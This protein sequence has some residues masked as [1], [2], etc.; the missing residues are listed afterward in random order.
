MSIYLIADCLECNSQFS[1]TTAKEGEQ[2][3]CPNCTDRQPR[4][5]LT[6][7]KPIPNNIAGEEW[8]KE[9][10][11]KFNKLAVYDIQGPREAEVT[12]RDVTAIVKA[13][14]HKTRQEAIARERLRIE[15]KIKNFDVKYGV[16]GEPVT[17][18]L[19]HIEDIKRMILESLQ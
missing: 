16:L 11:E 19:I 1:S 12:A 15:E 10:D 17:N 7:W 6:K 2:S 3:F 5:V 8:E 9:Y 13:F 18:P 4:P 14:I